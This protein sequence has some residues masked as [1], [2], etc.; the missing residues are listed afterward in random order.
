MRNQWDDEIK[1][2]NQKSGWF[3]KFL[4]LFGFEAEEVVE[5]DDPGGGFEELSR[6]D[7]S[8][9]Q[10]DLKEQ[11]E[12][13]K[14]KE[15]SKLVTIANSNK[16]VKM[17]IIEP[18]NFEEVQTIVDH[19]KNKQTVILNLEETDKTTA[20][21][22]ADFLGGAIYALDGTMQKISG[23]IF[24][25]TPAN[26]EVTIP[27]RTVLKEREKEGDRGLSQ[28]SLSSTLFRNERDR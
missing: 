22:I 15:H 13:E 8:Y 24:L 16:A 9:R 23:S 2:G 17:I 20:R 11:R 19:L 18:Q 26:I 6:K 7:R 10:R 27:L 25:F 14:E 4:N 21:R 3:E 5:E 1:S 28:S 12:R